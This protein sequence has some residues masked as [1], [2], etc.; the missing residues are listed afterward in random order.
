MQLSVSNQSDLYQAVA[1]RNKMA[2]ASVTRLSASSFPG[3]KM[4][5]ELVATHPML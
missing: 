5:S 1:A 4:H 3:R 2:N